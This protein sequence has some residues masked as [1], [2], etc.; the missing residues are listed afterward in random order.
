MGAVFNV[1]GNMRSSSMGDEETSANT[2]PDLARMKSEA[3]VVLKL[4]KVCHST[5]TGALKCMM[6]PN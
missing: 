5:L 3:Q 6:T 4:T 1:C 2:K